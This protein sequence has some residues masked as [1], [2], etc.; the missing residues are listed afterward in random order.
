MELIKD[1]LINI[2]DLL[3]EISVLHHISYWPGFL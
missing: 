3:N 2:Y 1:V